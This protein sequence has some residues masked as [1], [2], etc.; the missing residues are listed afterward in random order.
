MAPGGEGKRGRG[1]GGNTNHYNRNSASGDSSSGIR[2]DNGDAGR[3]D[4][5]PH[6]KEIFGEFSLA[7]GG[8]VALVLG[9][10]VTGVDERVLGLCDLVVEVR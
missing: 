7:E 6:R 5:N 9:N 3:R 4:E 8:V 2:S 1:E 10:E